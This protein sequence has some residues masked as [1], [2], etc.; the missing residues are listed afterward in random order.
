MSDIHHT[1]GR[2][3]GKTVAWAK[4]LVQSAV[5]HA[6]SVHRKGVERITAP[7]EYNSPVDSGVYG[8]EVV[9]RSR[10]P[11]ERDSIP[12]W[13]PPVLGGWLAGEGYGPVPERPDHLQDLMRYINTQPAY[14]MVGLAGDPVRRQD[15]QQQWMDQY[16]SQAARARQQQQNQAQQEQNQARR[17]YQLRAMAAQRESQLRETAD[18]QNQYQATY[19]YQATNTLRTSPTTSG[20][21]RFIGEDSMFGTPKIDP[22]LVMDIGL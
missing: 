12:R 14:P 8:H 5:Q 3:A 11:R 19:W 2:R 1:G 7:L 16:E 13:T 15:L 6:R 4:R 21:I 10:A 18:R 9:E 20:Y 17:E 22:D